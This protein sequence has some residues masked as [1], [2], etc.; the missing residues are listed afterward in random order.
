MARVVVTITVMPESADVSFS[1]IEEKATQII[2]KFADS[3]PKVEEKPIAF[4]LRSLVFV[5]AMDED[6]GSTESLDNE[7]SSIEGVSRAETTD[8]RRTLG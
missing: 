4:G 2:K 6:I 5:F 8:V 3:T 7:L 1:K